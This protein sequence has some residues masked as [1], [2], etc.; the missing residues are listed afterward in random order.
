MKPNAYTAAQ[1]SRALGVTPR[2]IRAR[3]DGV[4]PVAKVLVRGIETAAWDFMS[5]P[6]ALLQD[7]MAAKHKAEA[8]TAARPWRDWAHFL[9]DPPLGGKDEGRMMNLETGTAKGKGQSAAAPVC[10]PAILAPFRAALEL[11]STEPT[12]LEIGHLWHIV[13]EILETATAAGQREKKLKRALIRQLAIEAP[14]LA[15]SRATFNR[16]LRQ[17]RAGGRQAAAVTDRRAEAHFKRRAKLGPEDSDQLTAIA[18]AK[19]GGELAPAYRECIQGGLLQAAGDY[20]ADPAS[21][22]Y[23]PASIRNQVGP[24]IN[25]LLPYA[26]RPKYARANGPHNIVN[27]ANYAAGDVFSSD[28]FTLEVYF[29][30]DGETLT[31]GQFLPLI[32]VR[33]KKILDFI[34]IPENRYTGR[35]I[36]LLLNLSGRRAYGLPGKGWHVEG[37]IWQKAKLVGGAVPVGEVYATFADRLNLRIIP[38]LPGNPKGKVVENLGGI[39]QQLLREV[40]GWVGPNEQVLKIEAVQAAK[41]DVASG[42][43]TPEEA[44][45]LSGDQFFAKLCEKIRTYNSTPQTGTVMSGPETKETMTPDEAWERYQPRNAA[46]EVIG[47]TLLPEDCR[48]LLCSHVERRQVGRNGIKLR[49]SFGGGTYRSLDLMELKGREVT[50][51]FDPEDTDTIS[52]KTDEKQILTVPRVERTPGFADIDSDN[53]QAQIAAGQAD[54]AAINKAAQ[55]RVSELRHKYMP[56]PRP[57]ASVDPQT[58]ATGRAMM[59]QREAQA[60]SQKAERDAVAQGERLAR[61]R[62]IDP[63]GAPKAARS[64]AALFAIRRGASPSATIEATRDNATSEATAT[65]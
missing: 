49:D 39:F 44:G 46:G 33:S 58:A 22:S 55:A 1:L 40:P 11:L 62:G 13:F 28:D 25:R 7:L 38:A 64:F 48:Y 45:F 23:V 2:A 65:A 61:Q 3:L 4:S 36:R 26:Q 21:K 35:H 30:P 57:L 43:K 32:D 51:Y 10:H 29:S 9:S 27:H 18:I 14:F 31:R 15:G 41:L 56:A 63:A 20:R 60:T 50:V 6:G 5:L 59:A 42:R 12:A 16:N 52:I 8:A 47:R 37:G 17:W 53:Q 54:V 19:H 24:E 34:L